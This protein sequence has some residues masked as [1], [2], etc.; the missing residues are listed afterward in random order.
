MEVLVS[1]R[2]GRKL[3]PQETA[4]HLFGKYDRIQC[5]DKTPDVSLE[6]TPRLL[7][8]GSPCQ[9]FLDVGHLPQNRR[10]LGHTLSR[11][12]IIRKKQ[13]RAQ[14]APFNGS[15]VGRLVGPQCHELAERRHD[16]AKAIGQLSRRF[17]KISTAKLPAR[18][19]FRS[20]LPISFLMALRKESNAVPNRISYSESG[21]GNA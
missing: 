9:V 14:F 19:R 18:R 2:V 8:F 11:F 13:L 5:H 3:V 17:P 4:N 12:G 16:S 7:S 10:M 20:L 6:F 21:S 1:K 15:D